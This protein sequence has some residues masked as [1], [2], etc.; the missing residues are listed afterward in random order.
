MS[1]SD[2][3]IQEKRLTLGLNRHGCWMFCLFDT[4][5]R[6]CMSRASQQSIGRQRARHEDALKEGRRA[7]TFKPH[8]HCGYD[9]GERATDPNRALGVPCPD[10]GAKGVLYERQWETACTL[11]AF[12]DL[13]TEHANLK[14]CY[15]PEGA[16]ETLA[17]LR[18]WATNAVPGAVECQ[19]NVMWIIAVDPTADKSGALDQN[20]GYEKW[21]KATAELVIQHQPLPGLA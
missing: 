21:E 14:E 11:D 3:T 1:L 16:E 17:G 8:E 13:L 2:A 5:R 4:T 20:R 12:V 15:S 6:Y 7:Y 10:C 9:R 19:N 18:D